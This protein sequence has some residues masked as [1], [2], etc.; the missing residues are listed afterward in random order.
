M[1][2]FVARPYRS[3]DRE[4][5]RHICCETADKGAPVEHFFRDRE[6]FA[7]L[8]TRYYT[9]EEPGTVWVAESGG[10]IVGYLTGCLDTRRYRRALRFR[11]IPAAAVRA[12]ARGTLLHPESW[13]LIGKILR[14]KSWHST[15][16]TR[17]PAHFH[18]DILEALRGQNAGR[19]LVE[20]FLER[21]RAHG[22]P[23]IHLVTRADNTAAHRF[24]ERMGFVKLSPTTYGRIL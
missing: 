10:R 17:Y 4:A 13:K 2:T 9:D 8:V 12:L 23:G 15:D 19:L 16:L 6:I 20:K 14:E 5:V 1:N 21:C 24:F 7:D 18:I 22:V 11:I 3:S